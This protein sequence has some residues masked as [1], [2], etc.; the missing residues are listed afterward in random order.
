MM[1]LLRSFLFATIWS[2][3]CFGFTGQT[4]ALA[5]T[6]PAPTPSQVQV[7]LLRGLGDVWSTGMDTLAQTL[8]RRGYYAAVYGYGHGTQM[9]DSPLTVASQVHWDF[10]SREGDE[11]WWPASQ[12]T[13]R[14]PW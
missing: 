7:Y 5:A 3:I 8:T 6:Q 12:E 9:K 14:Q 4:G 13:C 1:L 11:G 10:A 2:A